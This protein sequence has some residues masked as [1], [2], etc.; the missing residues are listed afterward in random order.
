MSC[1]DDTT[2]AVRSDHIEDAV[3]MDAAVQRALA[4]DDID[5][6]LGIPA[7]LRKYWRVSLTCVCYASR[8]DLGRLTR[9]RLRL[10]HRRPRLRLRCHR[11]RRIHINALVPALLWRHQCVRALLA[12][13]L[14]ISMDRHVVA[15][16]SH[17][18]HYSRL[19]L[20]APRAKVAR[21]CWGVPDSGRNCAAVYRC[22]AR[23]TARRKDG[24]GLGYRLCV[25]N[26]DDI[27]RRGKQNYLDEVGDATIC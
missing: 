25:F 2:G 20:G 11:Q 21:V 12:I 26:R 27:C 15:H 7:I 1:K 22:R 24:L 13:P 17:W 14:D 18:G 8:Q 5:R 4:E 6:E 16:A 10:V 9:D 23:D 19:D 3:A